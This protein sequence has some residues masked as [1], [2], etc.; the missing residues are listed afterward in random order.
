M[1]VQMYKEG[2]SRDFR[3]IPCDIENFDNGSHVNAG[4]A[5]WTLDPYSLYG[6]KYKDGAPI[7]FKGKEDVDPPPEQTA[8]AEDV[9]EASGDIETPEPEG[10]AGDQ[11]ASG[12]DAGGPA[13]DSGDDGKPRIVEADLADKTDDQIRKL[14]K[15]AG[16]KSWHN[17]GI[18]KI[19]VE[20]LAL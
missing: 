6:G 20:L 2:S 1:S 12:D 19:K 14:A 7:D 17:K 5:G 9:A 15:I 16:I 4:G 13:A 18:P 10:A 8:P 3:G 11:D